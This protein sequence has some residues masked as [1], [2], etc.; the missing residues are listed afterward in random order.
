MQM[1]ADSSKPEKI[2]VKSYG[3]ASN[4]VDGEVIRGCLIK[5]GFSLTR[6]QKEASLLI[7]NTCAVKTQTENKIINTLKKVPKDKKLIISGCLP[8]I[9]PERLNKEVK[10]HGLL[11]PSPGLEIVEVVEKVIKGETSSLL[12]SNPKPPLSLPRL[13]TSKT[14]MTIPICYGCINNCTYCCV[15]LAR[16]HLRSYTIDDISELVR[17]TVKE[18]FREIWLTGQDLACYGNDIDTNLVELLK[19]IVKIKDKF[20]IRL[21][22]MNPSSL[23]PILPELVNIFKNRKLFKFL[24]LPI[25]S[26]DSKVLK[27]MNRLYNPADVKEIVYTFRENLE[28]FTIATDIIYGFPTESD[29]AFR[30]TLNLLSEMRPDIIN[31]SRFFPRPKTPLYNTQSLPLPAINNRS[32]LLSKLATMITAARNREWLNWEGEVLVDESGFSPNSFIAR[33]FAYKPITIKTGKNLLGKFVK[34]RVTAH[35]STYLEG[36]LS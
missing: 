25:Q 27:D 6:E 8:L 26:G 24:H 9:N 30:N 33:N 36:E 10:W 7:F 5:E 11:G 21:G 35:H 16:G 31:I 14:I 4:L 2:F 1:P 3:C 18:G 34:I 12:K 29:T 13:H 20:L 17:E 23:R 28:V 22:M 32:Q 15:H 19:N